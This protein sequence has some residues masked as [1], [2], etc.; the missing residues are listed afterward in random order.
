MENDDVFILFG[1]SGSEIILC[2]DLKRNFISCEIHPEY[3]HMILDRLENKGKIK[4]KYRLEF[5]KEKK[6]S[7]SQIQ[8]EL[9][10]MEKESHYSTKINKKI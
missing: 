1:G 5:I 10:L 3:Y 8:T 7:N 4:D 6:K 9:Q 2:K